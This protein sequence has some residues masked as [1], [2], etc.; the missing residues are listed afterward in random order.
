V[1]TRFFPPLF[2][3]VIAIAAGVAFGALAPGVSQSI[4]TAIATMGW[5]GFADMPAKERAGG[6]SSVKEPHSGQSGAKAEATAGAGSESQIKLAPEQ[7][8]AAGIE[9]TPVRGGALA[10]HLTAP[11]V[12]APSANRVGRVAVKLI[13]MVAEL[14]KNLGDF[15]VKDEVVAVLE[16]REMG[17]AKSEY[18][19]AR[20]TND[21]QQTL[22]ERDKKLWDRRIATEQ[23]FLRAQAA[24]E[25]TRIKVELA[26]AKL[27]ILGL[28]EKEIAVLPEQPAATLAH[29]EIRSLIAGRVVERK[30]CSGATILKRSFL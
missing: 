10:H 18:L 21:L 28:G 15:V 22:F 8:A 12:I 30:V 27:F 17:D 16:S 1:F 11:G 26:R 20:L 3:I 24:A 19:A 14:R 2:P 29:Q 23:Q 6:E 4:R 13:G 7:I 9:T 25:V 5:P